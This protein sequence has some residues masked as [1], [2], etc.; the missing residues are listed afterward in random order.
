MTARWYT[1]K[2]VRDIRRN[3][4]RNV[5]VVLCVDGR[6]WSRFL[7][8]QNGRIDGNKIRWLGS[9]DNYRIWVN[10]W[11]EMLSEHADNPERVLLQGRPSSNYYVEQSGERISG[12]IDDPERFI[13]ELYDVLVNRGRPEDAS[14]SVQEHSESVL[15]KLN[16]WDR[17]E[18]NVLLVHKDHVRYDYRINNTFAHLMRVVPIG[19]PSEISWERAKAAAHTFEN[20]PDV[21]SDGRKTNKI[22]LVSGENSAADE[23]VAML[24]SKAMKVVRVDDEDRACN[25]LAPLFFH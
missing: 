21:L 20:T 22:A 11:R 17:V 3:E 10:F 2:Y 9:P 5:G 4:P 12:T 1:A 6:V 25:D 18:R 24:Q 13:E 16:V 8:E 7:G 15:Q 23:M 14:S 19:S